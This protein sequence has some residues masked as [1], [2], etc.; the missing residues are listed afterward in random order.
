MRMTLG[1]TVAIGSVAEEE[2]GRIHSGVVGE[3]EGSERRSS[4]LES[5]VLQRRK[6]GRMGNIC[7][8]RKVVHW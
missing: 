6:G 3:R 1:C 8:L 4:A 7:D 5:Q 2:P